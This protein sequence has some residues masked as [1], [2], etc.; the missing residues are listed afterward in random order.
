MKPDFDA[1]KNPQIPQTP[2]RQPQLAEI[3]A[4]ERPRTVPA[5]RFWTPLLIQMALL[6]SVPAQ[7]AYTYATGETVVLQTAPVDPYDFLRGYSQTLS[8]DI[9]NPSTLSALPGG[10]G[11]F[12]TASPGSFYVV[13]QKPATSPGPRPTPWQ[14][15]SVSRERPE[16]LGSDQIA[17]KGTTNQWGQIIYG[18]ESY[19]MPEDRREGLNQ[20]IGDVQQQDREAFV[21]E[22][23]VDKRGNAVPVSLWVREQNYRF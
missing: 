8:Y 16:S 9:S 18:L 13:L 12:A 17:L 5:W 1:L 3:P 7:S 2:Q 4:K 11:V 20:L 6:V 14:P 10:T 21:A 15:V 23:K 22:V 19:Y